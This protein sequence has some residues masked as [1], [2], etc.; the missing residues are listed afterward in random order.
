MH[1]HRHTHTHTHTHK[2]TYTQPAT[3]KLSLAENHKKA[4]EKRSKIGR[5]KKTA[6][7]NS[8][9]EQRRIWSDR[10]YRVV[11]LILD[12]KITPFLTLTI[13]RMQAYT[14]PHPP[15]L[16]WGNESMCSWHSGSRET[17]SSVTHFANIMG[18]Y[19]EHSVRCLFHFS[20]LW[21]MSMQFHQDCFPCCSDMCPVELDVLTSAY[22]DG[23]DAGKLSLPEVW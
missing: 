16:M 10:L 6:F 22:I 1:T 2:H 3:T 15:L 17:D 12:R 14:C 8:F 5:L 20:V 9:Q 7:G 11:P 18:I 23:I 13:Q 4:R 19:S 21:K